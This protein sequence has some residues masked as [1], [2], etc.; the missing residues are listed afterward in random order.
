MKY[1]LVAAT[2]ALAA[3]VIASVLLREPP[4][5]PPPPARGTLAERY[6][7][8]GAFGGH[9][10]ASVDDP[11]HDPK[12]GPEGSLVA[13]PGDGTRRA[14]PGVRGSG[15]AARTGDSR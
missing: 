6:L 3:I 1:V 10:D 15:S 4:A 11:E 14:V 5:P 2:A 9:G 8:L 7:D 12:R 13:R